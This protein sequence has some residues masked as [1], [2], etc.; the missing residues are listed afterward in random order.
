MKIKR[1]NGKFKKKIQIS[2]LKITI[3]IIFYIKAL[4]FLLYK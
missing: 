4:K 2:T 3:T 1:F